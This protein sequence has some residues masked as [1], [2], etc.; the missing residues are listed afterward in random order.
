MNQVENINQA[1]IK[2]YIVEILASFELQLEHHFSEADI[3]NA[4]GLITD[5]FDDLILEIE[6]N[7]SSL[8][9]YINFES[10]KRRRKD[11][12]YK[13]SGSIERCFEFPEEDVDLFEGEL[14]DGVFEDQL[15]DMK[16]AVE[17]A[18]NDSGYE[19]TVI[20]FSWADDE[21]IDEEE[22]VST[23]L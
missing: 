16:L 13:F 20:H 8:S 2:T 6:D 15:H 14:I 12:I 22:S 17:D 1:K 21:I 18:C 11:D 3:K 5:T 23:L 9:I 19:L 4:G 7:L 10:A